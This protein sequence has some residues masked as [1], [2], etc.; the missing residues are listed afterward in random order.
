MQTCGLRLGT[1]SVSFKQL[2]AC[3]SFLGA[4]CGF[5]D[6]ISMWQ[7][8]LELKLKLNAV[9]VS[10]ERRSLQQHPFPFHVMGRREPRSLFGSGL[11]M[12]GPCL[13]FSDKVAMYK[14]AHYVLLATDDKSSSSNIFL[15]WLQQASAY[16]FRISKYLVI[17]N[18][19]VF[20]SRMEMPTGALTCRA[21]GP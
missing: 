10:V 11:P 20:P 19:N 9:G 17:H 7:P 14:V 5:N 8:R 4:C 6:R 15:L 13:R 2:L 16:C 18:S 3:V 21:F 1:T 12:T